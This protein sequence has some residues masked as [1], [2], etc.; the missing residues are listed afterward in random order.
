[1]NANSIGKSE[2]D[3][4]EN[5]TMSECKHVLITG[6]GTEISLTPDECPNCLSKQISILK[7]RIAELEAQLAEP[8]Q[9]QP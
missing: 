2:D 7:A 8:P 1:M 6:G 5:E 4:N 9:E 3:M